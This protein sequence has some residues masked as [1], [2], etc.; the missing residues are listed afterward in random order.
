MVRIIH[1]YVPFTTNV[2]DLFVRDGIHARLREQFPGARIVELRAN[3]PGS[4]AT[5]PV[6]LTGENL[7]HTNH[8]AHLVVVGGSNMY[9]GP[10]W[11]FQTD[12]ESL[13]RLRVPLAF[14]GLGVGSV[15]G[16]RERP[17]DAR[18][19]AEIRC[20][21]QRAIGVGVRDQPTADFL[22]GLGLACTMTACP[23]T[24]VGNGEL[25]RGPVRRVVI[26]AP[27]VR[28]LPKWG[29][30]GFLAGAVM[31][32]T[33]KRLLA[34]L[35]RV[36]VHW[37]VVAQDEKD[38]GYLAALLTPL[39]RKALYFGDQ[40]EAYYQQFQAA[41]FAICYRLHMAISCVGW[42]VPFLLINF[43]R[44]TASFRDTFQADTLT[45]DAFN[46]RAQQRLLEMATHPG[47]L[48]RA[49]EEQFPAV[50]ARRNQFRSVTDSF[51]RRLADALAD[52]AAHA[53]TQS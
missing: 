21:H 3:D 22:G 47:A 50:L 29:H 17:L 27:P 14:I 53:S 6:G 19:L 10:R 36:G 28:F 32:A 7:K 2:G 48:Q 5:G 25:R 15:R 24:F 51:Y 46:L 1:H 20:S 42:G 16:D 49:G 30:R 41:D 40:T 35:T 44:R 45:F 4:R 26:S 9:E 8:E 18:S 23:A 12:V 39:G 33:F 52:G 34:R 37:E 13:Q 43:D 31:F 11:R 38:L